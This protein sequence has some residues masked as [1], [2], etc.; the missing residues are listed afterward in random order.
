MF[1]VKV[2]SGDSDSMYADKTDVVSPQMCYDAVWDD[3]VT[4]DQIYHSLCEKTCGGGDGDQVEEPPM[5]CIAAQRSLDGNYVRWVRDSCLEENR[6][7]CER[8]QTYDA[9]L[10]LF[11]PAAYG[12][13]PLSKKLGPKEAAQRPLQGPNST[14]NVWLEFQL[15]KRIEIPI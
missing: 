3:E 5:E 14:E 15:E 10:E 12:T 9:E 8:P 6:F 1:P 13:L 7:V 11:L 2:W 4:C